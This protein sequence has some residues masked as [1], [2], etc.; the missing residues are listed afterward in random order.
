MFISTMLLHLPGG[1][2]TFERAHPASA[3]HPA[4]AVCAPTR[5]L[6]PI[7]IWLS[8]FTPSSI[9][10]SSMVP[11]SIVVLAPISTS[12]PITARPICGILIQRPASC[13]MPNPSAPI[14]APECTTT[15]APIAQAGYTTPPGYRQLS[16]PSDTSRPITQPAPIDTRAPS[17]VPGDTQADG[18]TPGGWVVTG[19]NSCD[20]RAN[21]AE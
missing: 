4:I 10:V 16:S 7:W 2:A 11:R 8:S 1:A 19:L 12:S 18:C 21:E 5:T 13:A 17:R 6:W 20:T 15:R 3:T 14:T 9:T